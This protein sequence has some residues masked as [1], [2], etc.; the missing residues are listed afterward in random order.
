M[1]LVIAGGT[2]FIGSNLCARLLQRGDSVIVLTRAPSPATISASKRWVTWN[3]S[4]PGSWEE[5]IDGADGVVNLAGEPI[6]AKRWTAAQKEKIRSSRLESTRAL[7]RAIAQAKAKPGFLIN[8]SAVGYYGPRGDEALTEEAGPGGDFLARLCVEWE[9]EA[10]KAEEHGVRVVRL[11]TGIV[12]GKGGG[13]L[14][15]MVPAFKLFLGGPVGSG[16]QVVSWIHMDDEIGLILFLMGNSQASGAFNA[17][18]PHP[19]TM[20]EFCKSLARVLGRP[21]WLRVPAFA[22]RVLLGE[23]ADVLVTGQR[24]VPAKAQTLGYAF[25]YPTLDQ[26]LEALMPL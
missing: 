13:A 15:R 11:R 23:M 16:R 7:V 20:R 9:E 4:S 3:P 18:A 24:V 19:V 21:S 10:K 14:A 2:G 25:R 12:L 5:A 22:L 26:A 6:A 8:G 1:K 17:T